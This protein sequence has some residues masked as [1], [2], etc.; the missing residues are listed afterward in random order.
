MRQKI[1]KHIASLL[2][3][4]M[5]MT[6][7]SVPVYA[8][9]TEAV[10]ADD[11][12]YIEIEEQQDTAD[13]NG[14]QYA[15]DDGGIQYAAED[16]NAEY[17]AV[18]TGTQDIF[19]DIKVQ[20]AAD[21]E[22]P[23]DGYIP[24]EYLTNID[25]DIE[26]DESLVGSG[27]R[28][29]GALPV[30]YITEAE[31]LPPIR[32]QSP[33]GSCWSFSTLASCEGSLISQGYASA[34]D[35]DLAERA[36]CY[37]FYDLKGID[38]PLGNTL[39]D[40]NEPVCSALGKHDIYQLGGNTKLAMFTLANWASP[41]YES[42]APYEFLADIG[43]AGNLTVNNENR[44][45][46]AL[47][48]SLCY[49]SDFHLQQARFIS[50]TQ[51][52]GIKQAIMDNGIVSVSYYHV[53]GSSYYNSETAAY[54]TGSVYADTTNHAVS[55][56][57]WDDEFPVENFRSSRR[58]E[59]P[60]AW[61]IRNSWGS[62]QFDGG[63]MWIS[64]EDKSLSDV[65]VFV[66]EPGYNYD[67]NYFYTGAAGISY[68]GNN[69]KWHAANVYT[70][71]S[72]EILKAVSFFPQSSDVEYSLQ[73]YAGLTDL[74]NPM[75]GTPML[76]VPITG[77]T[78][79]AGLYT[80]P[81]DEEISLYENEKF[82]VVFTIEAGKNLYTEKTG[83]ST[84]RPSGDAW[85]KYI[86]Q[87]NEGQS[88][89]CISG[90]EI[91][92]W[93]DMYDR[94]SCFR[95]NAYTDIDVEIPPSPDTIDHIQMIT[96][97]SGRVG[98]YSQELYDVLEKKHRGMGRRWE[99]ES[100]ET[101]LS[102]N[103]LQPTVSV[104]LIS[105]KYGAGVSGNVAVDVT[106]IGFE[107]LNDIGD[108]TYINAAQKEISG[109]VI[110]TG[111][112]PKNKLKIEYSSSDDNVLR[113][114][115][116]G[117]KFHIVP[118]G[119]GE[120]VI[121]AYLTCDGKKVD[122]IEPIAKTIS[123]LESTIS[124]NRLTFDINSAMQR[125]Y[126]RIEVINGYESG[127][128]EVSFENAPE[129]DLEYVQNTGDNSG[130]LT[131]FYNGNK[132]NKAM[133]TRLV[134]KLKDYGITVYKK[135]KLVVRNKQPGISVKVESKVDQLYIGRTGEGRITVTTNEGRISDIELADNNRNGKTGSI[136]NPLAYE[137]SE[138]S[139]SGNRADIR[140]IS[141][142]KNAKW[143]KGQLKIWLEGSDTPLTKDVTIGYTTGKL[144]ADKNRA[145][146]LLSANGLAL[147]GNVIRININ[148]TSM[149]A[150]EPFDEPVITIT[151]ADGRSQNDRYHAEY[152]G[153]GFLIK[154]GLISVGAKGEELNISISDKL[155][156][157]EFKLNKFRITKQE[158]GRSALALENSAINSYFYDVD[159][160]NR[161]N[162]GLT[163]STM[164]KVRNCD[165]V[166]GD[167][168]N[169]VIGP[170]GADADSRAVISEDDRKMNVEL[171]R[172]SGRINISYPKDVH[173]APGNYRFNFIIPGGSFEGQ[174]NDMKTTLTVRVKKLDAAKAG[175]GKATLKGKTDVLC[176]D[177]SLLEV[178][179][180]FNNVPD[181]Y[182]ITG[183]E[184]TGDNKDKFEIL[185]PDASAQKYYIR[186]KDSV[187][188][189]TKEKYR[190]SIVCTL[191]VGGGEIITAIPDV[192]VALTQSVPKLTTYENIYFDA[193]LGGEMEPLRIYANLST[194]ESVAVDR[195]ELS[196]P[197]K[198]F[199]IT[200]AGNGLCYVNYEPSGNLKP[201]NIYTLKFK[202]YLKDGA[203]DK[204]P[205]NLNCKVN[206][207]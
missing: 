57:G 170:V 98:D 33:F 164:L 26:V 167:V 54:Y 21:G 83:Q 111:A 66:C 53:N 200:D 9:E 161:I 31:N 147:S 6:G 190:I 29:R 185:T 99:F 124:F 105:K 78:G 103:N 128:C 24:Q 87:T 106:S 74:N 38:D 201:G 23:W 173:P 122:Y 109:N 193:G 188:V 145:V 46:D 89:S 97:I 7:S 191:A 19:D 48:D 159:P 79:Y 47:E 61:L 93:S 76:S 37:F 64:Y 35:I 41:V 3:V 17:T 45:E 151:D 125:P 192:S 130:Y 197:G 104:N 100:P 95:I 55:I 27:S 181:D 73:I 134:I 207:F 137:M 108:R 84:A 199:S 180:V 42:R 96:N 205:L 177:G 15:A 158:I 14:I 189:S 143:N 70:A 25:V 36:L 114:E 65:T 80:I 67:N 121:T 62:S 30:K 194:G 168:L 182:M 107:A 154:P 28:R 123:V 146:V 165:C 187:S 43:T 34:S 40:Y 186:L 179:P 166:T 178:K 174:K 198:G 155:H 195:I 150:V 52:E 127:I 68:L 206:I 72:D 175:S 81:L 204:A 149:K 20:D 44:G 117:E 22:E 183:M 152:D 138:K 118:E 169:M 141:N 157:S 203:T 82:S 133:E 131:A 112:V 91:S 116:T 77:R 75:S 59:S 1:V 135:V 171:D 196:N 50:K 16:K 140:V 56:V 184:F 139:I 86:A 202:V 115:K 92:G 18:D 5:I 120:A 8:L 10:Q 94:G 110:Y 39:G 132:A 162:N 60:G 142:G 129:F 148:N 136:P 2:T 69:E 144:K 13:D 160:E 4:S 71:G 102:A 163:A 85:I 172:S 126:D 119:L 58:P 113:V 176:R 88:F 90:N 12:S 63:Y 153:S 156:A 32:N 49:Q 11:I 101:V 51:S